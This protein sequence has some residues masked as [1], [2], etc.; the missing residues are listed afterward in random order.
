MKN[1]IA[2]KAKKV[3]KH[4]KGD[5]ETFKHEAHEDR[6][7]IKDLKKAPKKSKKDPKKKPVLKAKMKKV[8]TEFK[9]DKLHSG[10]KKG[11]LVKKKSQALAIAFSEAKRAKKKK[12]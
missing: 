9:D 12:K 8:M 11:P 5:I 1:K 6:E 2:S 10:S 7:L 4:L 3:V